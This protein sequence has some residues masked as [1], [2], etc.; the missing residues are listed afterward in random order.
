[1][2]KIEQLKNQLAKLT[3]EKEQAIASGR[4]IKAGNLSRDITQI[5]TRIANMQ[6]TIDA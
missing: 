6:K 3:A 1:M 4:T 5:Q 2:T